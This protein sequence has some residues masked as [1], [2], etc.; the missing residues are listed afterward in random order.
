MSGGQ[1]TNFDFPGAS[2]TAATAISPTGDILG[3]YQ[4]ANK[5]N[6]G[7]LLTGLKLANQCT[8]SGQ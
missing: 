3:R 2:F 6:H 7:F 1:V 4:D 8:A 5:V